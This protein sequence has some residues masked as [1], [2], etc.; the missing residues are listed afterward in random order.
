MQLQFLSC[1]QFNTTVSIFGLKSKQFEKTYKELQFL[2]FFDNSY[3]LFWV[4]LFI[5]APYF[6]FYYVGSF[7]LS[8]TPEIIFN[9]HTCF[10]FLP[11]ICGLFSILKLWVP[12]CLFVCL[13]FC[14][15]CSVFAAFPFQEWF[16]FCTLV[17]GQ[18]SAFRS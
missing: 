7:L 17:A 2:V 4:F 1:N 18:F 11:C 10:C 5:T 6:L 16:H 13:S 12:Q 9:Q 3:I 8:T 15:T 14:Y